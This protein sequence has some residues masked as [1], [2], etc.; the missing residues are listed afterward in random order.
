MRV[1]R[2]IPELNLQRSEVPDSAGANVPYSSRFL[3]AAEDI[4][5]DGEVEQAHIGTLYSG[6]SFTSS[7][8]D[9][10]A[11]TS[12]HPPEISTRRYT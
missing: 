8:I 7:L 4:P 12:G 3:L 10:H 6:G 11:T 9:H 2:A 1:D 5:E